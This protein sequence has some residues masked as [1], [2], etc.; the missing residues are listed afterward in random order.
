MIMS[1]SKNVS[2]LQFVKSIL[3]LKQIVKLRARDIDDH[4]DLSQLVVCDDQFSKKSSILKNITNLSFSRQDEMCIKF[5]TKII[6][7]HFDDE[8]IIVTTIL[9][10]ISRSK[11]FIKN[12]QFYKRYLES[13]DELVELIATI[14]FVDE[15]SRI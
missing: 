2:K 9:L 8:R 14:E 7:R 15:F 1:E 5:L 10:M 4:V 6:F 12:F 3:R 13:F 11:Q